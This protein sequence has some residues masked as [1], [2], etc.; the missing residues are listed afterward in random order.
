VNDE[1]RSRRRRG[2]V[3][4]VLLGLLLALGGVGYALSSSPS[5]STGAGR[6]NPSTS[7]SADVLAPNPPS[8][9]KPGSTPTAGPTSGAGTPVVLS[10]AASNG[11][12]NGGNDN[13]VEPSNGTG[14]CVKTFGVTVGQAQALYPDLIRALPVTYSNPN[15]FD[16]LVTSYRISVSVPVTTAAACPASSLEVPSGTVTL[17]PKLTA[18][19]KGSVA[20]TIPIKLSADAPDGCQLVSFTI[21]VN[22]TAVKR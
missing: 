13:C 8:S 14:N 9:S 3:L 11:N 5:A 6:G 22:A 18:P 4:G 1:Q 2:A 10:P 15:Q 17:N 19:K 21:T 12:D 16:I 20:T 7:P